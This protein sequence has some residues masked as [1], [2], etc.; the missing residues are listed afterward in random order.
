MIRRKNG[1]RCNGVRYTVT[2]VRQLKLVEAQ[3]KWASVQ[4]RA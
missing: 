2:P 1:P 4:Q 3:R